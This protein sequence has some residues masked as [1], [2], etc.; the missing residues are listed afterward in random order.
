MSGTTPSST[1]V[2]GDCLAALD[3]VPA[4]AARLVYLDPPFNTGRR[5]RGR[6]NASFEDRFGAP[7]DYLA[8]LT[9]RLERL[10]ETLHPDGSLIFHG[11]W[12]AIHYAKVALDALFRVGERGGGMFV[13]EIIWHYGLGAARA[14]RTLLTKHDTLL[15]YSRSRDYCF[16]QLRGPATAAMLDKYRHQAAD[17]RRFMRS[18]GKVYYLKG[19]KPLDDVWDIPAL[20]P[21]SRERSGYPTQKPLALLERIID[22]ASRPGDLVLDPFCGSG[23]TL[24]AARKLGRSGWGC[25]ISPHALDIARARLASLPG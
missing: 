14:Q 19:G 12:R 1:L 11:D 25:D 9:P 13:N 23:T 21:T 2:A 3:A 16:N 18:Y 10:Y 4:G 7:A 22:L 24:V 17:G 15:W 5:Q 6:A 20:A 8:F